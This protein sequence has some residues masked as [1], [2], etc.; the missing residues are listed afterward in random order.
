MGNGR[1]WINRF[2]DKDQLEHTHSQYLVDGIKY[3]KGQNVLWAA[4]S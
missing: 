1:C 2:Q 4:T 3:Q